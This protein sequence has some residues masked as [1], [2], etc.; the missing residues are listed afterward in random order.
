MRFSVLSWVLTSTM[1]VFLCTLCDCE[2][3]NF[4]GANKFVHHMKNVH[5]ITNENEMNKLKNNSQLQNCNLCSQ[6]VTTLD[7]NIH[8]KIE[9]KI[10][11]QKNIDEQ[12]F[13]INVKEEEGI[14]TIEE[15][16]TE[17]KQI[18]EQIFVIV[19]EEEEIVTIEDEETEDK[20]IDVLANQCT[21]CKKLFGTKTTLRRHVSSHH[22]N[23]RFAC[24]ICDTEFSQMGHM[25]RHK[26]TKHGD[27]EDLFCNMCNFKTTRREH[28]KRHETMNHS[29]IKK[30][31]C[32]KCGKNFKYK[33]S[34]TKHMNLNHLLGEDPKD[35]IQELGVKEERVQ[36]SESQKSIQCGKKIK[37]KGVLKK[38]KLVHTRRTSKQTNGKELSQPLDKCDICQKKTKNKKGL[39]IHKGRK[40]KMEESPV[41][42]EESTK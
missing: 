19:K 20:Q 11:N 10:R 4:V 6:L 25:K 3:T 29:S 30:N 18:D 5:K 23:L 13:V 9:H 39:S 24:T 37:H 12:I 31:P 1:M 38:R 14:V 27:I 8:L 2:Q 41:F 22:E 7:M 32:G 35:L 33:N 36:L 17:D 34:L 26:K 42:K 28:L 21:K 16:E 40:H 15:E